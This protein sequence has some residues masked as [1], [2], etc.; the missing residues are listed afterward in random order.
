MAVW[1]AN[2]KKFDALFQNH[3]LLGS[4]LITTNEPRKKDAGAG[5]MLV[6]K[7]VDPGFFLF[8]V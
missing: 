8:M 4:D 2:V 6:R 5:L 3:N 1:S 7:L